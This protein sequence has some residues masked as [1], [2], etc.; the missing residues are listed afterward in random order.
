[1]KKQKMK[2]AGLF[3]AVAMVICVMG[4][5][6]TVNAESENILQAEA[7]G[8]DVNLELYWNGQEETESNLSAD[9]H[10]AAPYSLATGKTEKTDVTDV[11]AK[12]G[13]E[14]HAVVP[15]GKVLNKIIITIDQVPVFIKHYAEEEPNELLG[16]TLGESVPGGTVTGGTY[17]TSLL[18]ERLYAR[19]ADETLDVSHLAEGNILNLFYH[20]GPNPGI[21]VRAPRYDKMTIVEPNALDSGVV[22]QQDASKHDGKYYTVMDVKNPEFLFLDYHKY[23]VK[24][25]YGEPQAA[26]EKFSVTYDGN[27]H[28]EGAAPVDSTEYEAAETVTVKDQSTLEKEGYEFAG[29]NTLADGTGT[30]YLP[31]DPF[32]IQ[33]DIV[34]YA[35]WKSVETPVIPEDEKKT[36]D[37]VDTGTNGTNNTSDAVTPLPQTSDEWPAVIPAF[38]MAVSVTVLVLLKKRHAAAQK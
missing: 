3:M 28:T 20:I 14:F 33:G 27:G 5:G 15:E 6:I 7:W 26:A 11:I 36:D 19:G 2:K 8:A 32:D 16:T 13:E 30:V 31:G 23:T 18:R 9:F 4:T 10:S 25:Y 24:A 22:W 17:V 1:M 12:A 29:W 35:Q 21:L 34:L 37:T 38:L